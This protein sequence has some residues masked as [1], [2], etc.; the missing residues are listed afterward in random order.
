MGKITLHSWGGSCHETLANTEL[1]G[2]KF[3][4]DD[5]AWALECENLSLSLA[6]HDNDNI[7]E[8]LGRAHEID[9]H[10]IYGGTT[11][12]TPL[13]STPSKSTL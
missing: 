7:N 12:S 2:L 1:L 3:A 11:T 13:K 9:P 4:V 5:V 6:G 10:E 8:N